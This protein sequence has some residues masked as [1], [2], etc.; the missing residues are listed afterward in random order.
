MIFVCYKHTG[1]VIVVLPEH[2]A[3]DD[4]GATCQHQSLQQCCM[5]PSC[6]RYTL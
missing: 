3:V 1:A 6:W 2:D 4:V 5:V